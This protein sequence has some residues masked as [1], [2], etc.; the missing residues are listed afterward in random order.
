MKTAPVIR[1]VVAALVVTLLS[2][3]STFTPAQANGTITKTVTVKGHDGALLNGATVLITAYVDN[4]SG[5]VV[6]FS[7]T[8]NAQGVASISVPADA[9]GDISVAPSVTDTQNAISGISQTSYFGP[10]AN[11]PVT[12]NLEKANIRFILKNPDGSDAQRGLGFSVRG[13]KISLGNTL[14]ARSGAF[15][16]AL[17]SNLTPGANYDAGYSVMQDDVYDNKSLFSFRYGLRAAGAA[18]SQTYKVFTNRNFTTEIATDS[19]GAF[20]L[21]VSTGNIVGQLKDANG[22]NVT[23]PSGVRAQVNI[24]KL[25]SAGSLD[26]STAAGFL[27][28]GGTHFVYSD[29]S[30]PGRVYGK[31]AGK[32]RVNVTFT[33]SSTLPTFTSYIYQDADGKF[34]TT[35]VSGYLPTPFALNLVV[36][37]TP[38]LKIKS[39]LP[40]TSTPDTSTYIE[41]TGEDVVNGEGDL[42]SSYLSTYPTGAA[43]VV[44]AN[45]TYTFKVRSS[46]SADNGFD[47]SNNYTVVVNGGAT[48]SVTLGSTTL[49]PLSDGSYGVEGRSGNLKIALVDSSTGGG[50]ADF[51]VNIQLNDGDGNYGAWVAGVNSNNGLSRIII[52]QGSYILDVYPQTQGYSRQKF[53]LTVDSNLNPTITGVTPQAGIFTLPMRAANAKL[54]FKVGGT[55]SSAGYLDFCQGPSQYDYTSCEGD[56]FDDQGRVYKNLEPGNYYLVVRPRNSELAPKTYTASVNAQGVLTVA[57]STIVD[58][59]WQVTGQTPNVRFKVVHPITGTL[60]SN[61]WINIQKVSSDGGHQYRLP[62]AELSAEEPGLTSSYVA[63]GNYI[64]YVNPNSDASVSGLARKRYVMNVV[65]GVVS[66]SSGG[67]AVAKD[68]EKWVVTLANANFNLKL[69]TPTGSVLTNSWF[70]IC[71]DTGNG[72]TRTGDCNGQGVNEQG[73]GSLNVEPGNYYLRVNP[74][75]TQPFATK[76]YAMAVAS[77]G[78]VTIT[79][80]TKTGDFWDVAAAAPNLTGKILGPTG[81]TLTLTTNQAFDVQ[82]QKWEPTKSFWDYVGS[83][84]KNAPE[85]AFNVTAVGKYRVLIRPYGISQFTSTASNPVWVNGSSQIATSE[86]GSYGSTLADFNVQLKTP[87]VL[88]DFIDPRDSSLIKFG[89]ISAF[90]VDVANG[91]QSWV[92]NGDIASDNP[93]KVGFNFDDG[94]YRLEVN[95]QRGSATISGLTR[96]LYKVVVS[97]SGSSVVMTGW[98]NTTELSKS[99]SRFLVPA[100]SANVSGRITDSAGDPLA[101]VARAWTNI[102]V[103]KLN[104]NGNWD[105]T[106]NW[107]QPDADGY[108]NVNVE[109][110]GT[111]RLRVEPNGRQNVTVSFSEQFT[112]TTENAATF[113]AEFNPLKLSAPDLL[114]S[115]YQGDTPT[116]LS[117][118][119]VEIRKNNQWLDWVNTGNNGVAGVS[120]AG[121]GTYQLILHPN[122]EQTENGFT[123]QTYE[124][125][126]TTDS[127]GVK[128]SAV[129]AKAGATKVGTLNKLKLGTATLSGFL[130]LPSSGSNAVVASG[131]VLPIDSNGRE[132]WEYSSHTSSSGK[133]SMLLPAG[134]YTL[135]GRSPYGQVTYGNGDRIGTVT[136]ASDGSAT[137]SGALNGV[138]PL[139]VTVSLK[140]PTWSGTVRTPGTGTDP[141]PFAWLCLI[142]NSAWNCSQANQQGQWALSAPTGFTAFDASAELRIEDAQNR[143]YPT[144]IVRGATAVSTALGGV[145]ATGLIHRLPSANVELTVTAGGAAASGIWVNL[146]EVNAGWLG[147][148]MTDAQGKAKFYVDPSK[149]SS[150]QLKVNAEINGNPKYSNSFASSSKTF[151]GGGSAISETLALA[152]PNFRATL[153]E[154]TIAGVAGSLVPFSWVEL[155]K[156][157]GQGWD[158]KVSGTSTDAQGQFALFAPTINSAETKYI[159]RVNPPWNNTSTSSPQEYVA[160]V[161]S[162]GSVTGVVVRSKP[163]VAAQL[164]NVNGIDYWR[165]SLASPTIAGVV[166]NKDDLPIANSWI[167]SYDQINDLWMSGVNSR[168]NGSFYLA[169]K[170]GTYRFEANVPWGVTN[171][172]RS[173]QCSV[174]LLN[175]AVTTGGS[176]VQPD[177]SIQ[178]KLRAPNVTFT[179]MS[180]SDVIPFASVGLGY[181]GWNTWAQSD[182]EGKVAIFVDSE[183]IATANPGTTGSIAPYMWVDPP[184]NA[185]N[186]M[187]RWDCPLGSSKPICNQLPLVT[188]G[189]AYPQKDL[190]PI[191][192]LKPNTVLAIKVPG[193][194]TSIGANAWINLISFGLNGANQTWAGSN[195]DSSGNAYFYL[196]TSTATA[197]TRWGVTVT[198]PWDKR[199]QYSVKEFG[200]YQ[201]YGDWNH[202]LTW[203]S[204][205]TT[206]FSPAVP[207][208]TIT[209]NRPTGSVPNRY[210]WVQLEE[211]D[212][213]GNQVAWKN[214]TSLDY[215]GRSSLLLDAGKRYRLTAYPNGG[216]GTRTTCLIQTDTSTPI[217]FDD[218]EGKCAAGTLTGSSLVI[219]LDIGNVR[220]TVKD[221]ANP[222][223]AVAGAIVAAVAADA[224]TLTTTTNENGRFGLDLDP[225]KTWT[226][227]IIPS[228]TRLANKTLTAAE[229]VTTAGELATIVLANR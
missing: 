162:G 6:L 136:I 183:A 177:K 95:P 139:N 202:G 17:P 87:N 106:D 125:V 160:T 102:N 114:F 190:G 20:P 170:D 149:L 7:G 44:L 50:L 175:N 73:E 55:P 111:Y 91:N 13:Q 225:A 116:A 145:T 122:Q 220:G 80:A 90:S 112:I 207:N 64:V 216:E 60:V 48:T 40:G 107:Y 1:I 143:L 19:D 127:A 58:G 65:G 52:D 67:T 46:S 140:D 223:V 88:I 72:P 212:S 32:Y 81:E 22:N 131:T 141:I 28:A 180:G 163:T 171:T 129:T 37:S 155:L 101:N 182:A 196:D 14:V 71:E 130:R 94:T 193:T 181:G 159:V 10:E 85:Y 197:D 194:S 2:P 135:Q 186:K 146:E 222:G 16:F 200:T 172:A 66:I 97:G 148:N 30:F 134:T 75:S 108:F 203:E 128:T 109:D 5:G 92:G 217:V 214:G 89:W 21:V 18:G 154:P 126:V 185:N 9:S 132:L 133:W 213:S 174:T 153:N 100:G 96:K 221:S 74:G 36:P 34:S 8:T 68:G 3:F 178:L 228:G 79:G 33:G 150:T 23:I 189:S 227:T 98:K 59:H 25:N 184:W 187:V 201:E 167:N 152:V 176:C 45:G 105:W 179:L 76:I 226:I 158:E 86:S 215:S 78:T 142:I 11:L 26:T 54:Q 29:G 35:D 15:G 169:L 173:A 51:Y 210:G 39:F 195:T 56:G 124:V 57:G 24:Q 151:T 115:V 224:T 93:G 83:Q 119:G 121:A 138:N 110:P 49:S 103:Q 166:L 164:A 113:K 218:V 168:N 38:T 31:L 156:E 4:G 82:L 42:S 219:S 205:T 206:V 211:V 161:N 77:D 69:K 147:S 120:F 208:F 63:D 27:G 117:N 99:G 204:L 199:Q 209:V 188:I 192:V 41:Y 70:D 62:N 84:W 118:V 137:L 191:E 104:T 43:T 198:P 47:K 61:G 229:A 165:L 53:F 12:I 123:R 157:N 144:L